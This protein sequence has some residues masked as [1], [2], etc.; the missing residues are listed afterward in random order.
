MLLRGGG[1]AHNEPQS[2]PRGTT[3]DWTRTCAF[4]DIPQG[5]LLFIG[6]LREVLQ[7]RYSPVR[8]VCHLAQIG[9]GLFW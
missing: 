2:L 6:S 3:T 8:I 1:I 4:T 7:Y 5:N 9:E